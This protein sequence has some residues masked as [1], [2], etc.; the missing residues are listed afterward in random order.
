[1]AVPPGATAP[2]KRL[3]R[4]DVVRAGVEIT[5]TEGL[6]AVSIRAVADKLG[7]QRPT[8]YHHM[9]GGLDELRTAIVECIADTVREEPDDEPSA[10]WVWAGLERSLQDL[11]KISRR[12]PGVVQH[13]LTTGRNERL[14]ME[15]AARATDL[16]LQSDLRTTAPEA[17]LIIHAYVTGWAY[18]QRPSPAA[19]KARGFTELSNVLREGDA[20]DSE[21]VLLVGL[22]AVLTGLLANAP[23]PDA[24]E[25]VDRRSSRTANEPSG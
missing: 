18:S 17:Y 23:Q 8:L 1:M 12:Y 3:S 4:S 25:S 2:S 10:H 9:P 11:G 20:L 19:A 24:A 15:G 16:L 5:A 13:L 21:H 6:D 22:R 14:T 7:V